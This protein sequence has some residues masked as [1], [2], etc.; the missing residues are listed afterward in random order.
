MM[1]VLRIIGIAFALTITV[2]A[3]GQDVTTSAT[4]HRVRIEK[5]RRVHSKVLPTERNGQLM[6]RRKEFSASGSSREARVF[7]RQGRS[8]KRDGKTG[9]RPSR[10]RKAPAVK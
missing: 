6:K 2:H 1:T 10:H 9:T 8:G 5:T 3:Y 7:K 4:D